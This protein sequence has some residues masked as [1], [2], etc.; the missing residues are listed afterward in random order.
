MPDWLVTTTAGMAAVVRAA[1]G[2]GRAGQQV[3]LGGVPEIVP[4]LDQGAVAIQE[5]GRPPAHASSA[6][7]SARPI[8][9][10][11]SSGRVRGSSSTRPA[12]TRATTDG[13]PSL[14]RSASP[15]A[16]SAPGSSATSVVG[17]T[18]PGNAP[19]P[20]ADSPGWSSARSSGGQAAASRAAPER[21][22]GRVERQ[23]AQHRDLADGGLGVLVQ[24][25][26][27]LERRE[28]QLVRAHGARERVLAAAREQRL[29]AHQAAGLRPAE[30]L[31]A[32]EEHQVGAGRQRVGHARLGRQAPGRQVRQE[33]AAHVE[34]V[35]N[36]R[37]GRERRQRRRLG[38]GDEAS[39][40]EVGAVHREDGGRRRHR[41]ARR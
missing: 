28:G 20:T 41:A 29:P 30:Q 24:R 36:A 32:A 13:S 22:A 21:R 33:A 10:A 6:W 4:V 37:L 16:P 39:L 35:G 40:L 5:D 27:G 17:R 12:A 15:S 23:H 18:A 34:Q 26:R 38:R 31:V 7:A 25:Q 8:A 9:G 2:L 3:H 1:H 19:P 11:A 14:R